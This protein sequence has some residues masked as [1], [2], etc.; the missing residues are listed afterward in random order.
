[1]QRIERAGLAS[2]RDAVGSVAAAE[3]LPAHREAVEIRFREDAK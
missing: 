1:V 2:I 3:G